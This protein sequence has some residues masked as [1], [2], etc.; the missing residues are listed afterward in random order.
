M[1]LGGMLLRLFFF[2]NLFNYLITYC[3]L[4][5]LSTTMIFSTTKFVQRGKTFWLHH[6]MVSNFDLRC[7]DVETLIFKMLSFLFFM[8][9]ICF[10]WTIWYVASLSLSE[11]WG[12]EI[13]VLWCFPEA[14]WFSHMVYCSLVE[15]VPFVTWKIIRY[16]VLQ[17]LTQL[18]KFLSLKSGLKR[19]VGWKVKIPAF[20][21]RG[22]SSAPFCPERH[23]V[24]L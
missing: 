24:W 13:P 12:G 17:L 22:S 3:S 9:K 6:R 20:F 14:K 4:D 21:F 23:P 16:S 18:L 10:C 15:K 7:F 19:E 1:L 5:L 2:I 8:W 11:M